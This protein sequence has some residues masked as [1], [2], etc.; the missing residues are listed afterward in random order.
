MKKLKLISAIAVLLVLGVSSFAQQTDRPPTISKC[1]NSAS[2]TLLLRGINQV[3]VPE[4]AGAWTVQILT[5]GGVMGNGKGNLVLISTGNFSRS[6]SS[7]SQSRPF[8][9]EALQPVTQLISKVQISEHVKPFVQQISQTSN[10][11]LCSDCFKT[12]FILSRREADGTVKTFVVEWDVTTKAQI[13]EEVLQVYESVVN[14][15]AVEK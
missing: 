1:D 10:A 7:L 2:T 5:S 14:L 12:T 6:Q 11:S 9:P 3:D 15:V 4:G 8:K 13:P